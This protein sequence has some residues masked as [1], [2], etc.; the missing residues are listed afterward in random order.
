MTPAVSS[1]GIDVSK[2]RLDVHVLP[3]HDA[4]PVANTPAGHQALIQRLAQLDG[5]RIVVEASG[6]YE[7]ALVAALLAAGLHVDLVNAAH[8]RH[9]AR[10]LG[11]LAKTDRLDAAVLARFAASVP[12]PKRIPACPSARK[13]AQY[14]AYRRQVVDAHTALSN[15]LEH[16]GDPALRRKTLLLLATLHAERRDLDRC[17]VDIVRAD[18]K[19]AAD[20]AVLRRV[21]GIGPLTAAI[22]LAAMPELGHL[23]RHKIAAL[24][25]LAP[26]NH[27]SGRWRGLRCISGGRA[28]VRN[29]LY[30]AALSAIRGFEPIKATFLRLTQVK[31]KPFKVAIVACMRKL[32]VILNAKLRDHRSATA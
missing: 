14:L 26:Y 19:L 16:A 29:A 32:I 9:Y 11:R 3:S 18:P 25:G 27:D 1:V 21:H 23:D 2:D 5:V 15:Q 22:L 17:L 8:V 31:G 24:V 10:A 28:S 30:M 7:A 13:L 4:W 6:G 20:Y 12:S